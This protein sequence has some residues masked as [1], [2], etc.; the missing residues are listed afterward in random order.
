MEYIYTGST[1]ERCRNHIHSKIITSNHNEWEIANCGLTSTGLAAGSR[2]DH[3]F[4][5]VDK[6]RV[7][8]KRN[9][10]DWRLKW[11]SKKKKLIK[12]LTRFH[13]KNRKG[14]SLLYQKRCW[15]ITQFSRKP[16]V[17]DGAW[18]LEKVYS[19]C[20]RTFAQTKISVQCTYIK[21][22]YLINIL[23]LILKNYINKII[24][25]RGGG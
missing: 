17:D 6:W 3:T 16:N 20:I 11:P 23:I 7:M 8:G 21:K 4:D 25:G 24:R 1:M 13:C 2:I 22:L 12:F 19:T 18:R 10:F 14:N 15:N 9:S 5:D